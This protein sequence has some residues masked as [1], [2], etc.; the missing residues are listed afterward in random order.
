MVTPLDIER[1][2]YLLIR[3]YGAEA[4]AHAL[5]RLSLFLAKGDREGA[6]LWLE[7]VTTIDRLLD[8]DPAATRH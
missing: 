5:D 2:S 4:S 8:D 3:H 6:Q 1:S 7:I